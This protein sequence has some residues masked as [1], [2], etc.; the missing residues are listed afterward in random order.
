[1]YTE[2]WRIEWE[3]V[4]G[5]HYLLKILDKDY[6]GNSTT[7]TG[8]D[9]PFVTQ[10]DSDSDTFKPVRGQTGYIRIVT[11]D[12]TL[13]ENLVPANNTQRQVQVWELTDSDDILVWIGFL[14]ADIYTQSWNGGMKEIEIAVNSVLQTLQSVNLRSDISYGREPLKK[15]VSLANELIDTNF[16]V[17]TGVYNIDNA[18]QGYNWLTWIVDWQMFFMNQ[19]DEEQSDDAQI[20]NTD[21]YHYG[22]SLYEALEK[23]CRL[24]GLTLQERGRIW[25]FT[26]IDLDQETCRCQFWDVS[27]GGIWHPSIISVK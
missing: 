27:S 14:Q 22:C 23:V 9:S 7:L 6:T 11:D 10:E 4:E 20:I 19:S 2:R 1:M 5:Q 26:K 16:P 3:S 25:F 12:P 15:L 18:Q 17:V 13:M 8:G 21:T 24:A